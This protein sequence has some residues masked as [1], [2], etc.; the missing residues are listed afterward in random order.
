MLGAERAGVTPEESVF[1]DDLRQNCDGAEA[2]GMTSVLH[3][4]ADTTLPR[5]EE[6]LGVKLTPA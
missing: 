1:V 4:G 3:R 6:L 2:V 5:L